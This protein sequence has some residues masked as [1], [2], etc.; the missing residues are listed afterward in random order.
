MNFDEVTWFI[1]YIKRRLIMK[2]YH[3]KVKLILAGTTI[4]FFAQTFS[5]A[6]IQLGSF[7][8]DGLNRDYI[9][10]LP[11]NF[12]PDTDMPVVLNLHG[13]L[14]DAQSQ[15]DYTL[16][17]DVADTAG[18]IVV[19]PD[20]IYPGFN[21]G[22][23]ASNMPPLPTHVDDVG[24]ISILIDTLEA[25]YDIDTN[26][27]YCCGASNGGMMTYKISCQL[28][29]RFAAGASVAGVLLD[30]IAANYSF[31]GSLPMLICNGTNDG[32]VY[33]NGGPEPM[34]W[35]AEQTLN[36]WTQNNNCMLDPDTVSI[37]DTCTTDSCTVQ[38][39]SY[40]DSSNNVRVV[41]Y[42]VNNGG[43]SWP[44]AAYTF[45]SAGNTNRDINMNVEIWNFFKN[46]TNP[47]TNIAYGKTI[48][49]YPK[50]L[51]PQ[52]DTLSVVATVKNLANHQVSIFTMIQG[53]N[54]TFQ[55][56]IQ[57]YD[58]GMHGDEDP[59]DNI[60]GGAKWLSGL[61][62][63]IYITNLSSRDITEGTL[64]SLPFPTR[65]TTIGPVVVEDYFLVGSD[66][67]PN[68]G[69]YIQFKITL[70]NE[71][72]TV[73][74]QNISARIS[75][76]D[77]NITSIFMSNFPY[78]NIQPG[79]S[80]VPVGAYSVVINSNCPPS[81]DIPILVEISSGDNMF[82]SDSIFI[83]A[84]P[85]GIEKED[86]NLPKTFSLK[87][88]YPNP[89]NPITN[90]EFSIPKAETV[91]LKI[92]NILGQEVATLVSDKLNAGSYKYV[93]DAFDLAS[94]VY[95]YKIEA[96]NFIQIHKMILLK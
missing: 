54:S 28:G 48:D 57:L 79:Q 71:G 18:F 35:S 9:V 89:F 78:G 47:Y 44:Q 4:I 3:S 52:G 72:P 75:S 76:L 87:Q 21:T 24:F 29:H 51:I 39:I 10:F 69:D 14:A 27:I 12:Q 84:N 19:Y 20:A 53:E 7:V 34:M 41:F 94:G 81:Y 66:T 5:Y 86:N 33:Y 95:M 85:T 82:W 73:A 26:R 83:H 6:Q 88:N 42:K 1:K 55:D 22:L 58:D 49:V 40:S 65:F 16:M 15:L 23:V 61:A 8:F 60:W 68:S 45:P 80:V 92:Y 38:K 91:T 17:N 37:A 96:G 32:T 50:Y 90:I 30:P 11:Q 67:I 64:H 62:E 46:Y 59:N 74:A 77:S 43:H 2:N 25:R 70:K 63:D 31:V 36:F 93:W 13:Y 56:S